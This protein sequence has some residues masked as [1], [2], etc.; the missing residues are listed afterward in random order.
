MLTTDCLTS[1]AARLDRVRVSLSKPPTRF[2]GIDVGAR[3]ISIVSLGANPK[4]GKNKRREGTAVQWRSQHCTPIDLDPTVAPSPDWITAT[5]KAIVDRLPRCVDGETN[6]A[7]ISLPVPWVHY[8]VVSGTDLQAS[9]RQCD[10]MFS[11]SIFR[12]QAQTSHWPVVGLQHGQ[13]NQDDQYVVAST[14]RTAAYQ[15]AEAVAD[16]GYVVDS[17]L[18]HGIALIRAASALTAVDPICVAMLNRDG[19]VV[20]VNHATDCGLCRNLPAVPATLRNAASDQLLQLDDL[21]PW[22][23]DIASEITATIRFSERANMSGHS[24][25]PIMICG[26][27]PEIPNVDATLA[28]LTN[29]PIVRWKYQGRMR[30]DRRHGFSLQATR[31]SSDF[32]FSDARYAMALSLAHQATQTHVTASNEVPR[33]DTNAVDQSGGLR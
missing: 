28:R 17:I 23:S 1:F 12:S 8:Q 11:E 30:P 27:I 13:P 9:R 14:A 4:A 16:A 25:S 15:V 24:R 6:R 21:R 5:T 7:F 2:V 22:L 33:N 18:P 31:A 3:D 26:D 29:H 19:G 32:D 20:A 10:A